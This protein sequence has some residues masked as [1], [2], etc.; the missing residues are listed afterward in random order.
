MKQLALAGT[1]L[2]LTLMHSPWPEQ[3][4]RSAYAQ[5]Q[6]EAQ[7]PQGEGWLECRAAAG[8]SLAIYRLGRIAYDE[9]RESGDYSEP[10]RI[11]RELVAQ[12]DRNGER[13]LKM[14]HLQLSWGNHKDYVQAYVWMVEDQ[15]A[16][17]DYLDNL[18]GNLAARMTPEQLAEA[19]ELASP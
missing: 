1:A 17:I 18:I 13:L 12:N 9:S 14:T 10:L 2:A 5:E 8:D 3:T 7:C 15:Q 19:K 11:G 16:G 6:E 4:M